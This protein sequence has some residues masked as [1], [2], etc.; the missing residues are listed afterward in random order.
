[1]NGSTRS[2]Q[3]GSRRSY[4]WDGSLTFFRAEQGGVVRSNLS[5]CRW[6]HGQ[7]PSRPAVGY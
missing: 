3:K 1:M 7:H 5:I 2:S 4:S 6:L